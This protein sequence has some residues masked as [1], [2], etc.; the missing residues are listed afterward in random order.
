M[1]RPGWIRLSD[2]KDGKCAQMWEHYSGWRVRH[3][4][5]PTALRPWEARGPNGENLSRDGANTWRECFRS[6]RAI[7]E[8]VELHLHNVACS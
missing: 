5:H 1:G 7:Q 3:C 2:V 8:A 4:G 6:L